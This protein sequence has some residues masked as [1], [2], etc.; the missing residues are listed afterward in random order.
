MADSDNAHRYAVYLRSRG[1]TTSLHPAASPAAFAT[2]HPAVQEHD[3]SVSPLAQVL[4]TGA[5]LLNTAAAE[6]DV[7]VGSPEHPL[8]KGHHHTGS[9]HRASP[10][11][12]ALYRTP[13]L[14]YCPL[15][16]DEEVQPPMAWSMASSLS[17]IDRSRP[18]APQ[19]S[20]APG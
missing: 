9:A 6:H 12:P 5:N 2:G 15:A 14:M 11:A 7:T 17:Q 16:F 8:I 20:T 13:L 1:Y 3:I 10:H 18:L 4:I 19:H